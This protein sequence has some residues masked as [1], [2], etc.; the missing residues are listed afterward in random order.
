M[1]I[2]P[3]TRAAKD[4]LGSIGRK[5]T[6][7]YVV[8]EARVEERHRAGPVRCL[9]IQAC[10]LAPRPKHDVLAVLCPDGSI[11]N[12]WKKSESARDVSYQVIDPDIRVI[13]VKDRDGQ[14]LIVGR[15][16][17]IGVGL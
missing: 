2:A 9:P 1:N 5:R 6:R 12:T 17:R 15:E 10:A 13:T 8:A 16:P 14:L 7:K 11:V 3:L 4:E